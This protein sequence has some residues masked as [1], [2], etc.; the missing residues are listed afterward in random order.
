MNRREF[1]AASVG[2]TVLGTSQLLWA[3]DS[4][5]RAR[6]DSQTFQSG[7]IVWPK[8]PGVYVPYAST[9]QNINVADDE[10]RWLNE[11]LKFISSAR[12]GQLGK[13][14]E[15][16]DYWRKVAN[17]IEKYDFE[18]FYDRYTADTS[19]DEY[20]SYGGENFLY[21]GHVGIIEVDSNSH[22]PSVIEAVWGKG[23]IQTHYDEWLQ[24]RGDILVW[25]ARLKEKP[26]AERA[27]ITAY[28]KQ[29]LGKEYNFWNFDLSNETGFYCSKLVWWSVQKAI[30]IFLDDRPNPRRLIWYS[31]LQTM[32]S[33]HL[34]LLS[35]P[36]SYRN[37]LR[38][39]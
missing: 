31:P 12:S 34:D 4:N 37:V 28:A 25:H 20:I 14:P 13:T 8:K 33:K 10:A 24:S 21:V 32:K 26:L 38:N 39:S 1:I 30:G 18:S 17:N 16:N 23:V 36:G 15:E 7:D 5:Y 9:T 29:M 3:Q 22:Q 27:R 19:R 11:R 2:I 35:T 6:P